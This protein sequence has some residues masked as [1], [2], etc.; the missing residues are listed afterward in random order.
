MVLG[1]LSIKPNLKENAMGHCVWCDVCVFV[2]ACAH[3]YES[4]Q[5]RVLKYASEESLHAGQ[6]KWQAV[7]TRYVYAGKPM[8]QEPRSRRDLA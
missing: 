6:M 2:C 7:C 3:V 8:T 4:S 5:I 1:I